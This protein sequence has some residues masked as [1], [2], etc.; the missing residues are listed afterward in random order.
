MRLLSLRPLGL[1]FAPLFFASL[2]LAA[3]GCE[4]PQG[5][6][7]AGGDGGAVV[8]TTPSGTGGGTGEGASS[9][10]GGA[11]GVGGEG[12]GGAEPAAPTCDP[13][14]KTGDYCGGDKVSDADP[15]T[16]YRCTGPGPAVV[17][18][19]CAN[20]CVVAPAGMDDYCDIGLAQ[21]PE[22]PLLKYGLCPDASDHLRCAGLDAGDISQ[23]IG[24][25]PASA[26]TH[27]ADGTIG[28]EPYCA[29]T[30][31]RT[32]NLTNAQVKVLL[33]ELTDQGFAA[34]F[35]D[36]GKDGWP[37]NEARHIHAIYVGVA[38]KASLRAQ[39]QDWLAGK[40]GLASHTTYSFYQAS[41]AKKAMIE[42][43]FNQYN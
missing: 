34:F 27:A 7:G 23:T 1:A 5:A 40:N 17:Q 42:A 22:A 28:G 36:P 2:A 33:D 15:A 32:I 9:D 18:E 19:V 14:A 8:S 12:Q 38:M 25:A 13:T 39:V 20:G 11:S 16:L 37:S 29:A 24:N 43:L 10:Q 21:C 6:T 4:D 30:D 3:C 35:R 31:L 41:P 26:G